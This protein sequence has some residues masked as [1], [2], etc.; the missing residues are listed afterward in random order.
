[1]SVAILIQMNVWK[2]MAV[3]VETKHW[4]DIPGGTGVLFSVDRTAIKDETNVVARVQPIEKRGPA[5][6]TGPAHN[7]LF[8]G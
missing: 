7:L 5:K 2:S 6:I 1:M 8:V 4:V 3:Q